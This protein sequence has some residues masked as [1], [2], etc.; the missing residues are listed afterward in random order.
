M[1]LQQIAANASKPGADAA[2]LELGRL[3]AGKAADATIPQPA[4]VW[5]VRQLE[6]MGRAEAVPALTRILDENDAELRDCARRALEKNPAPEAAISLRAALQKGG[7]PSWKIGLINALGQRMDAESAA[8]IIPLLNEPQTRVAAALALGRIATPTSIEAL[9]KA[10]D[11]NA[12]AA[13]ALV[14]AANQLTAVS[15][16]RQAKAIYQKLHQQPTLAA[17]ARATALIGLA[18]TDATAAAPLVLQA[19]KGSEALLQN[20][21]VSAAPFALGRNCSRTLAKMMPSLSP[22]VKALILNILDN[23]AEKVVVESA[24]DRDGTVRLAA[25]NAMGRMGGAQ[26]VPVLLSL[27]AS[28]VRAEKTT[29]EAA[30]TQINGTGAGAAIEQAASAGESKSRGVAIKALVSRK[31]VRA[32]P[33]LL[34]CAED[35]DEAV[36]KSAFNALGRLAGDADLDALLKLANKA[37]ASDAFVA[38]EATAQRVQDKPA[39]TKK[40]LAFAKDE[41]TQTALIDALSALGG[42]EALGVV[43]RLTASSNTDTRESAIKALGNWPDISA[44][45]PLLALAADTNQQDKIHQQALQAI[46]QLVKSSENAPAETLADTA[47]AA[48]RATRQDDEKKLVLSALGFVPHP[49]AVNELKPMLADAKF[50]SEAGQAGIALAE[51]LSRTDRTAAKEL[52]QAIKDAD[53]S[54]EI[55]RRANRMLNRP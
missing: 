25:L 24:A 27:A 53:V 52:A 54:P 50:K 48:M 26:S 20:A 47:L 19:L 2:R 15:K 35:T 12:A 13:D 28:D 45:K 23:S 37:N 17:S 44:A 34:R 49:K 39:A 1:E 38:I 5:I 42:P 46:V 7:D 6:Y 11:N 51:R 18:K 9:W 21:A 40:L 32:M 31:Q 30:L 43:T 29:A 10:A 55:T 33:V 22:R 16:K 3:L 14:I 41:T 8:L 36:R 4:R